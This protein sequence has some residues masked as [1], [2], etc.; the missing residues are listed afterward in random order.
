MKLTVCYFGDYNSAHCRN[1]ILLE[2]L[3][4]NGVTVIE[5]KTKLRHIFKYWDLIKKHWEIRKKYDVMI[6][7]TPGNQPMILARFLTRKPIIFDA[8]VS[9][10]EAA[11]LDSKSV[12]PKSVRAVYYWLLDFIALHFADI[13]L[14]A[15]YNHIEYVSKEFHIAR[16]K[17][18]RVLVGSSDDIFYPVTAA[19]KSSD[20]TLIFFGSFIPLH[21]VEYIIKAAKILEGQGVRFLMIGNGQTKKGAQETCKVL[22]IKNVIFVDG[23][24]QPALNQ[25]IARSDVCLGIF[26]GSPQAQKAIPNKVYDCAATKTPIVTA[27]APG[28]RELFTD[29]D[30]MLVEPGDSDA[31]A[32][33]ILLLKEDGEKRN[34]LANNAYDKFIKYATI[35]I[36]GKELKDI[37]MHV[38]DKRL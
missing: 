24:R 10:Y 8:I 20:F 31:L 4:G 16:Q 18:R 25:E 13:V 12:K 11:V 27:D 15:T 2:G 6:V 22:G 9:L 34:S 26:S 5:C 36:L 28:M 38:R 21:G 35:N 14:C 1:R 37:I 23:M 7:G 19:K 17:F 29:Q 32:N 30:I 3:R 33:A